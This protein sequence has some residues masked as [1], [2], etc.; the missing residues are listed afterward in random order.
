MPGKGYQLALIWPELG[1]PAV[2]PA[3][4]DRPGGALMTEKEFYD[5]PINPLVLSPE[6]MQG[7]SDFTRGK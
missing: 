2:D 5:N 7:V 1:W 6:T 3:N 4:K